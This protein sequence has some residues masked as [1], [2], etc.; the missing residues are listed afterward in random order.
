MVRVSQFVLGD[1]CIVCL[2]FH[3]VNFSML[4]VAV[5]EFR[6]GRDGKPKES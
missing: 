1:F 6:A 3:C 2:G 4:A 5:C